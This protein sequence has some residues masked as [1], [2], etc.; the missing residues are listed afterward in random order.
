[1]EIEALESGGINA[2]FVV[3]QEEEA[4]GLPPVLII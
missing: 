3:N 4:C 2:T 1:M